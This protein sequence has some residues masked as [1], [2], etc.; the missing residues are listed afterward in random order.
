MSDIPIEHA[1][2]ADASA[3]VQDDIACRK[4]AYN[5]RG[6]SLA[7]RCPE[8]GSPV[9]VSVQGNLLRYSDPA[10]IDA[11]AKGLWITLWAIVASLFSNLLGVG[12]EATLGDR[13][14]I[15]ASILLLGAS[16]V[17]F[18]GAFLLTT[19]DPSGDDDAGGFNARRFVRV[20][21]LIGLGAGVIA[22]IGKHAGVPSQVMVG[23]AAIAG[24]GSLIGLAGE[25]AR[26]VLLERL[27]LRVP[28]PDLAKLCR[29]VR[30]GYAICL[31]VGV[32]I[33][34]VAAVVAVAAGAAAAPVLC[35]FLVAMIGVLVFA[36]VAIRVQYRLAKAFGEQARMARSTWA[37]FGEGVPAS[38]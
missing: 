17:G 6:L 31:G 4:C 30:W 15:L 29:V 21:L 22:T 33:G 18:W 25:F 1:G 27:A 3:F 26:Y 16:A 19:P 36:L 20:T 7:G 24:L 9:G 38:S 8:C 2:S 37:G 34:M 28:A 14:G 5:L 12:L 13:G 23:V 11:L 35:L 10:W 32:L